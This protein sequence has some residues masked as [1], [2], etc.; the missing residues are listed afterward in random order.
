LSLDTSSVK[1]NAYR[2]LGTVFDGESRLAAFEAMT[3]ALSPGV[4][5]EPNGRS[6]CRKR[7]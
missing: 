3:P 5:L 4:D 6:G 7:L 1:L 2:A